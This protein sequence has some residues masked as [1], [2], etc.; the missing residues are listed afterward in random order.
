MLDM[1]NSGKSDSEYAKKKKILSS[2]EKT[3]EFKKELFEGVDESTV[4]QI[5]PLLN[6]SNIA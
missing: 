5:N 2:A 3:K 6:V 1:L 4:N